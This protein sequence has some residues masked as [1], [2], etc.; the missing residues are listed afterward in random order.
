MRLRL[1][2][3]FSATRCAPSLRQHLTNISAGG[4]SRRGESRQKALQRGE[5]VT[6]PPRLRA[7]AIPVQAQRQRFLKEAGAITERW[8]ERKAAPCTPRPRRRPHRAGPAF[9]PRRKPRGAAACAG[10]PAREVHRPNG[11]DTHRECRQARAPT[12]RS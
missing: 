12:T 6:P 5:L 9:E 1:A 10:A 2:S 3:R 4:G 11:Q 7:E 8:F